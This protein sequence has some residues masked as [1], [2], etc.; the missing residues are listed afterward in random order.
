[1]NAIIATLALGLRPRQGLTKVRAK[2]EGRELHFV[3]PRMWKNVRECEKM[4]FHTPK[5]I[6]TLGVR[7]LDGLSNFQK[8][9][10][11]VKTHGI[12]KFFISLK[13]FWNID[14]WNGLAWPILTLKTQ[15]MAK[16]KVEN[17]ISNLTLDH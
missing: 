17:Q 16:R 11:R 8:T 7:S 6:L 9:I 12:E 2:C 5:W 10:T 1:L 15:V 4:N 14:V 13:N 3:F